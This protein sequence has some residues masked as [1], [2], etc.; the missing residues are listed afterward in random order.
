VQKSYTR[1][2]ADTAEVWYF[3]VPGS[4][5]P[6]GEEHEAMVPSG[7]IPVDPPGRS[8]CA[9]R[10]AMLA[11][12]ALGAC[13]ERPAFVPGDECE[14]N[15]DCTTPFVC[16]LGRCR[17]ECRA[18]RD[19]G[20][21]LEC[22]RD[23]LGLGACQ[24][25]EETDCELTSDCPQGF[26]CHF[27]RC[28]NE[29]VTDRDCPPGAH[30]R[31]DDGVLGCRDE[32]TM[33]CELNSDCGGDLICGVDE[34]CRVPCRTDWD[35]SD[36]RSCLTRGPM[37][38]CGWPDAD[39]GIAPD[40]S[41]DAGSGDAGVTVP[42]PPPAPRLSAGSESTCAAPSGSEP[43]CWGHN[44][45]GQLGDGTTMMRPSPTPIAGI[46]SASILEAG[47][48]HTCARTAAELS[49]WG[50]N[51]AGQLGTGAITADALTPV[52]VVGLPA[53][54]VR[55]LALGTAHTC[56]IVGDALYCW[57]ANENGQLGVGD[58]EA[59][60][61]P[62]A[63]AL[64]AIPVDVDAY[65]LHT[66][67]VLADGRLACFGANARGQIGNGDRSDVLSPTVSLDGVVDVATGSAHTC[68][69][70][71]NGSVWCWGS[72]SLGQLGNGSSETED[73]LTPSPT[74]ALGEPAFEVAAGG[75][76]SCAR[77]AAS[78]YCWGDNF[79]A[80]AGQDNRFPSVP[81]PT[82]VASL[83]AVEEV[84]AGMDHTCVRLSSGAHRCF[85]TNENGQLGNGMDSGQSH[86]PVE[87]TPW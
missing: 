38:V 39:A 8:A 41:T 25:P 73:V 1:I 87:V 60:L 21:G 75:A 9:L 82:A 64:P 5:P 54:E 48:L 16:R 20:A 34:R 19:C 17:N 61:T 30:C 69:L 66:C 81:A 76:H 27:R 67:V 72:D 31:S 84:A 63:V 2:K 74:M 29:C 35:C 6:P 10:F 43:R 79:R 40:A 59:R 65:G 24:L 80:Q 77:A 36:G 58:T 56:A 86:T 26:V 71:R 62:T 44:A 68:A 11:A 49:C 55:D 42:P 51:S 13:S 37:T 32:S 33:E 14:L 15:T 70:R 83:G 45:N 50:A 85:G 28:T 53:G 7:T 57:G 52:P 78:V 12:L 3:V 22:V 18:Q 23:E 4:G 46:S 47:Q